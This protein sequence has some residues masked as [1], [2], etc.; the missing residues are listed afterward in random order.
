MVLLFGRDGKPKYQI[1]IMGLFLLVIF[2]FSACV[3]EASMDEDLVVTGDKMKGD[4]RPGMEKEM[5]SQIGNDEI[6]DE[7][8]PEEM[9]KSMESQKMVEEKMQEIEDPGDWRNIELMD[10]ATGQ[11]FRVKDYKG[12]PILLESFAVW[13]SKCL[14]QQKKMKEL[15]AMEGEEIIHIALDTDPNED[16][17]IVRNHIQANGFDWYYSVAP[18]EMTKSLIEEFGI[19]I[20][21]APSVPVIL[22]CPDQSARLLERGQKTP[23]KLLSEIQK[24]C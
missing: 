18:A 16:E 10:V 17:S 2:L 5:D 21:S 6:I 15:R 23:E 4:D 12:K 11:T 20:V 13:C 7:M 22:I 24:G 8:T 19:T 14:A 3:D 1:V 9:E